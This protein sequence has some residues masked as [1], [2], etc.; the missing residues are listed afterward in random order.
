[1]SGIPVVETAVLMPSGTARARVQVPIHNGHSSQFTL[2]ISPA[3]ARFVSK[4]GEI[5]AAAVVSITR[6]DFVSRSQ[7]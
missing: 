3:V 1:M 2:I 4:R 6:I 5:S 7:G